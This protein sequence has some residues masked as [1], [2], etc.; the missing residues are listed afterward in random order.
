V[1]ALLDRHFDAVTP[2]RFGNP[3]ESLFWEIY[4]SGSGRQESAYFW[5]LNRVIA[6]GY[7]PAPGAPEHFLARRP[8]PPK[9]PWMKDCFG[10]FRAAGVD[11][12]IR[13]GGG[14]WCR[15]GAGALRLRE[16]P[17]A[18]SEVHAL[19][20]VDSVTGTLAL[21]SSG[22]VTVSLTGDDGGG[23]TLSLRPARGEGARLRASVDGRP[24]G[25]RV[26][27][28]G[29][30]AARGVTIRFAPAGSATGI[31]ESGGEVVARLPEVQGGDLSIRAA[32]GSDARV[33]LGG[34]ELQR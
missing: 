25:Q 21:R 8:G 22:P 23:W 9:H 19:D 15:D 13:A 29:G 1:R 30:A 34:L 26:E 33:T 7:A 31:Q 18:V 17:A 5:K 12:G 28:P 20:A 16:T 11:F 24:A 4:S 6:S 2:I 3:Q 32:R 27:L 10:P 14:F